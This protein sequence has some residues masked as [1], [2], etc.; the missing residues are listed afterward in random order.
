VVCPG[1]VY[2]PLMDDWLQMQPDPQ[3]AEAKVRASLP[4]GKIGTPRDIAHLVAFLASDDAGYITG[5]SL[6]IDGGLSA[7]FA[8]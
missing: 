3:A 8:T 7:K 6:V 2:T 1:W 4:M 5:A